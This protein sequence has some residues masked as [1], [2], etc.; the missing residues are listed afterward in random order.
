M[1]LYVLVEEREGKMPRVAVFNNLR[2]LESFVKTHG[3]PG[4]IYE[5]QD[6]GQLIPAVGLSDDD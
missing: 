5:V 6:T 2:D 4:F 3:T 1:L